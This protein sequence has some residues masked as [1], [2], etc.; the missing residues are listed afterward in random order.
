MDDD[1]KAPPAARE[2][3]VHIVINISTIELPDVQK[4]SREARTVAGRALT[5][6]S[7][8]SAR[9]LPALPQPPNSLF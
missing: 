7:C 5:L 6:L 8:C 9:V 1:Y 4:Y 3:D 2:A